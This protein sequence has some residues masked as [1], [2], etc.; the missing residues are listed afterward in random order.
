MPVRHVQYGG[1]GG[2]GGGGGPVEDTQCDGYGTNQ[3]A[4]HNGAAGGRRGRE[5]SYATGMDWDERPMSGRRREQ[6]WGEG[7]GAA[8]A[9]PPRSHFREDSNRPP[10]HLEGR[11][12]MMMPSRADGG[13][14]IGPNYDGTNTRNDAFSGGEQGLRG[15]GARYD[16]MMNG[17]DIRGTMMGTQTGGG[18]GGYQYHQQQQHHREQQGYVYAGGF[19]GGGV[20]GGDRAVLHASIA[21]T[22]AAKA[23][24][25]TRA[26]TMHNPVDH[27]ELERIKAKKD[28]YRR[29]LEAQVT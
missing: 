25:S 2:R 5:I 14:N 8:A 12:E 15:R 10:N 21:A 7:G 13:R 6:S 3:R 4:H 9:P 29:D 1:G 28:A 16:T 11:R 20:S 22:A 26:S 24:V 19:M 27:E 23:G 17:D 18:G